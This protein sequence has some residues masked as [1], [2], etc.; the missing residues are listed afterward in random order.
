MGAIDG[1]A[2]K[3]QLEEMYKR[4]MPCGEPTPYEQGFMDGL[5]YCI[6]ALKFAPEPS[7]DTQIGFD[8]SEVCQWK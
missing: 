5:K 4:Y 1:K 6:L 7:V 8:F 2:Y 3:D